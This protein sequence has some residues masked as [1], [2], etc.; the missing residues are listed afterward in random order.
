MQST[1][2]RISVHAFDPI[3]RA[4][5][6]SQ[7]R[8][9]REVRIAA[10]DDSEPPQVALV[11]ADT[12]DEETLQLLKQMQRHQDGPRTVL[13]ASGLDDRD[14]ISS[15]E[16]GVVGV[17]RRHEATA[18]RLVAVI[19][20]AAQNEGSVPPDLLGRLLEQVGAV[21]R[22][23]LSPK[24]LSFTGLA[25]REIEVLRLVADGC[26]THEIAQR[27]AYSERTV[28]NVLHEVTA[29]LQLRNRSHAVAYALRQGL[30]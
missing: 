8:P 14:L 3:L 2:I 5:V 25:D 7:L 19:T 22:G 29:R 27:L 17:L 16:A 20:G 21:Q 24:G 10:E 12:V 26:D 1:S 23:M 4:G 11:V 9:R 6:V 18:D 15:V 30:I 13:V 28:K